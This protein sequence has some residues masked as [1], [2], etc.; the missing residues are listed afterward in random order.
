MIIARKRIMNR[1]CCST[2]FFDS[3]RCHRSLVNNFSPQRSRKIPTLLLIIMTLEVLLWWTPLFTYAD[4]VIL[5]PTVVAEGEPSQSVQ[6]AAIIWDNGIETLHLQSNY[7]GSVDD[8]CWVIP[9]PSKPT[10]E[11]SSWKLFQEA[12]KVTRPQLI[13]YQ[14]GIGL[15]CGCGAAIHTRSGIVLEGNVTQLESLTIRELH[16]D[17]LSAKDSGGFIQWLHT[18]GYAI[19][20]RAESIL[21]EYIARE[22]FFIAAKIQKKSLWTQLKGI[23]QTVTTGLTP[24]AITFTSER[25][26]YPLK[27]SRV[28]SAPENELLLLTISSHRLQP[29][30]YISGELI[31]AD[32]EKG[33]IPELLQNEKST[34]HNLAP[35]VKEAQNRLGRKSLIIESVIHTP[36]SAM[37]TD[38]PMWITRF[39]SF[40][41]PDNMED[42]TFIRTERDEPLP[43][44]FY[45]DE[46]IYRAGF[47]LMGFMFTGIILMGISYCSTSS[48][49]RLRQIAMV[50]FLCAL[51]M[52]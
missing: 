40:L 51:C 15:G 10:V 26:F 14:S 20:N 35:A 30:Q 41:T 12:E 42:M 38:E 46:R 3:T 25:P 13:G 9:V 48:R 43:K 37:Q 33:V 8:F 21:Q 31:G 24:L 49:S 4:G 29:V 5:V 28:T 19:P 32:I 44:T 23:Q 22:F 18:H 36:L 2:M 17:I 1:I 7:S 11:R 16:I 6:Q 50:L 34:Q 27:I 45:I 39:H 47:P 52:M